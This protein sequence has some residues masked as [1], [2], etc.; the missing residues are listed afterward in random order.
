MKVVDVC[1]SFN[2]PLVWVLYSM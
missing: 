1:V 2:F